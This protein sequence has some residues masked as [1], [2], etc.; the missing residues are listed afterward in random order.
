[1]H[2]HGSM[3][4]THKPQHLCIS[5]MQRC[6]YV[7]LNLPVLHVTPVFVPHSHRNSQEQTNVPSL[8]SYLRVKKGLM[9]KEENLDSK[10]Y[11]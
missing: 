7:H 9:E 2:I 5:R 3:H 10:A 6:S 1:M 11:L 4:T 8:V